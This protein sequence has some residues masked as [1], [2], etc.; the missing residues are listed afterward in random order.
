M[1]ILCPIYFFF[2]NADPYVSALRGITGAEDGQFITLIGYALL[3][4]VQFVEIRPF[5]LKIGDSNKRCRQVNFH[6][7]IAYGVDLAVCYHR[8]PIFGE[9]MLGYPNFFDIQWASIGSIVAIVFGFAIWFLVKKS[10]GRSY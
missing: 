1:S 2:T 7:L 6:A 8:W 3:C 4:L 5:L 10:L 9:T